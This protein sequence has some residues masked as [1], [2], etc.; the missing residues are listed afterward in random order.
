[1]KKIKPFHAKTYIELHKTLTNTSGVFLSVVVAIVGIYSSNNTHIANSAVQSQA[2]ILSSIISII[3]GIAASM[4]EAK[5]SNSYKTK[6][7]LISSQLTFFSIDLIA[8][9]GLFYSLIGFL[10]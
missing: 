7:F 10:Y 2:V 9:V 4:N 1:M 6:C 3:F 8:M 5:P